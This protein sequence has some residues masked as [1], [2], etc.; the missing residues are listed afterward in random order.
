MTDLNLDGNE[1]VC[2]VGGTLIDG[3]GRDPVPNGTVVVEAGRVKV[4]G[5][6]GQ[7]NIPRDATVIDSSG[8]TVMPGLIDCHVHLIYNR[9][10]TLEDIDRPS[11]EAAMVHAIKNA[12]AILE[13]GFTTV[14]DC[15][16]RGSIAVAVRD[17]VNTGALRGPRIMASG[18]ALSTTAGLTDSHPAW[19]PCTMSLGH[20]VD[21]PWEMV[22][23]VRQQMKM[24]VNN[25]KIGGSAAEVSPFAASRM[26]T[27]T[28]EELGAAV[29]IAHDYER[30]VAFHCQALKTAKIALR[31]GVD[32]LE[33]GTRL[34]E[35]AVSMFKGSR[36]TLVPTLCT[37]YSVLELAE[38]LNLMP[39][40]VEEMR[41]HEGTWVN[42][43]RMAR[44]A[45]VT[46]ALGSDAGNR[47]P[48]G[49][50]ARELEFMVRHGMSEMEALE[51]GTRTAAEAIGMGEEVGTL[52]QGKRGDLLVVDGDPISDIKVLQDR[53]RLWLIVKGG[54]GVGG[55]GLPRTEERWPRTEAARR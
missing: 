37:L 42:S 34:D 23:A 55:Q 19:M 36:T 20:V 35:E 4:A 2:F 3:T 12:E 43:F 54:R 27:I 52:E 26:P 44:E 28:E 8:K 40:Q 46:M 6:S 33:H 32:T 17:G 50:G 9:Y 22:K 16:T 24:G 10:R 18:P 13:G 11:L 7:V 5:A 31:V 21:G 38:S 39:K 49:A 48:Q 41:D 45:G 53:A 14:R 47:Y 1:T 15:G 51:C 30:R 29:N 25:V